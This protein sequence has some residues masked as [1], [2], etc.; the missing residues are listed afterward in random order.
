MKMWIN[1]KISIICSLVVNADYNKLNTKSDKKKRF[2]NKFNNWMI[3]PLIRS[4]YK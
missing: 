1:Q 2:H 4:F 3:S